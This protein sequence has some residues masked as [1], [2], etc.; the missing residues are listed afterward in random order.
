MIIG[1][2]IIGS[3][4]ALLYLT[5]RLRETRFELYQVRGQRDAY[6]RALQLAGRTVPDALEAADITDGQPA[7]YQG[8]WPQR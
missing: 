4:I 7:G 6:A 8:R 1:I 3:L 2:Y 5:T